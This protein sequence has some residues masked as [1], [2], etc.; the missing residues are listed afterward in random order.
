MST[1]FVNPFWKC[2]KEAVELLARNKIA[3]AK[4]IRREE[5]VI[6]F[7]QLGKAYTAWLEPDGTTITRLDQ[8]FIADF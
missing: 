8:G 3:G 5:D 6:L 7:E 2:E 1:Q 4:I